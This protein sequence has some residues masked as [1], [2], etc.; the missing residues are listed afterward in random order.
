MAKP[1]QTKMAWEWNWPT[2]W[3]ITPLF[4]VFDFDISIQTD[5]DHAP[6]FSVFLIVCNVVLLDFSYYNIYHEPDTDD[7]D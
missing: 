5:G 7:E 4:N 1:L 3:L 2:I 6:G